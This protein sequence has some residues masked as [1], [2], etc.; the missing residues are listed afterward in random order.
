M[1]SACNCHLTPGVRPLRMEKRVPSSPTLAPSPSSGVEGAEH[2]DSGGLTKAKAF[3]SWRGH[4]S[5]LGKA[6]EVA[7]GGKTWDHRQPLVPHP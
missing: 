6:W 3:E 4:G 2:M 1:Q 5:G 7:Q